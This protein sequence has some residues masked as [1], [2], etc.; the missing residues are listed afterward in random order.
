MA[1][2]PYRG[3]LISP[4][5]PGP[6]VARSGKGGNSVAESL[7]LWRR[8]EFPVFQS[9]SIRRCRV[10]AWFVSPEIRPPQLHD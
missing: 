6:I 8:A 4:L 10:R 7:D 1:G 3:L 5:W 2:R 9:S